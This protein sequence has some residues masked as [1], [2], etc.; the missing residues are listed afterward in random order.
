MEKILV[1]VV[2]PVYS[3]EKYLQALAHELGKVKSQWDADG[4]PM[5]LVEAIFVDDAAVDTSSVVLKSLAESHDW[6]R[7]VTLSRNYGQHPATVAGILYTSGDWIVTLDEDLQHHP[8][9]IFELLK[10]A[11]AQSYDIVYATP[12]ASVHGSWFRDKCSKSYKTVISYLTNNPNVRHFNSFRM[13]RGAIARAAASVCG[14]EMYIDMV[15]GWFTNRVA[16]LPLRLV[17][18][19]Y[20]IERA[21]GYTVIKLMSHARRLVVSAQTK[22][23]RFGGAIGIVAILLS[24][25]YSLWILTE[26]I[27]SPDSIGAVGWT[28]L[29][30]IMLFFGGL[31]AF[32]IGMLLEYVSIILLQSQ[33]K[34]T[35]Y[36]V[37]RSQD[38]T[39]KQWFAARK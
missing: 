31:T 3:G 35:F 4:Y 13:I 34:P 12:I 2:I 25:F 15:F 1:S 23:L 29:M 22:I 27:F 20:K 6:V 26:K 30:I 39:L 11:V 17:D 32:L 7:V 5:C 21:S 24:I 10:I 33:G 9:H 19:R 38:E 37:D 8:S 16:T 36:V 14:H 18:E 28:S